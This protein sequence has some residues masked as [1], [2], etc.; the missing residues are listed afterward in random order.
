M[1]DSAE[2]GGGKEPPAAEEGVQAAAPAGKKVEDKVR[3]L[4]KN[5]GNA[6]ILKTT[7]FSASASSAFSRVIQHIQNKIRTSEMH[8]DA[9]VH[10]FIN[11]SFAPSPDE[12]LGDLYKCFQMDGKLVIDYALMEAWG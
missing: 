7:E 12:Q 2:Q 5:V 11:Q 6:P 9:V 8:K 3:I 4:V 1:A 10:L